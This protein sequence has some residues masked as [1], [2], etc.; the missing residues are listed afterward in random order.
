MSGAGASAPGPGAGRGPAPWRCSEATPS[1]SGSEQL[2]PASHAEAVGAQLLGDPDL[3]DLMLQARGLRP[4]SA[5]DVQRE[6]P[7]PDEQRDE[8]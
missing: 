7:P 5:V 1:G 4:G 3:S 6:G 2:R 8:P